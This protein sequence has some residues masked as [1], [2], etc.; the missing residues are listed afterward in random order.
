MF[1]AI[2]DLSELTLA[3]PLNRENELRCKLFFNMLYFFLESVIKNKEMM[4]HTL[5][6]I[7]IIEWCRFGVVDYLKS[8]CI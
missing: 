2:F 8:Y 6:K 1:S 5:G 7:G 3:A 4:P